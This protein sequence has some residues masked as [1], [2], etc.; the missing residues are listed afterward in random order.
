MSQPTPPSQ[1]EMLVLALMRLET[2]RETRIPRFRKRSHVHFLH[3]EMAYV[4]GAL[5]MHAARPAR[6]AAA[7]TIATEVVARISSG[8]VKAR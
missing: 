2:A 4:E 8:P 7:P 1:A 3:A 5:A 6:A